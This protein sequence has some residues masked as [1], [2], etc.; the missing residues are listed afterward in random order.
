M[1]IPSYTLQ[2]LT[3]GCCASV[4]L[5]PDGTR[6]VKTQFEGHE[7]KH[8]VEKMIYE[9]LGSHPSIARY[10]GEVFVAT[11]SSRKAG[12][13]LQYHPLR[14]LREV[15]REPKKMAKFRDRKL[16]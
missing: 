11:E 15:M 13:L 4:F 14:T 12:L 5:L 6:V 9:R 1:E 8:A 3:T 2:Y 16:E 10:Y 7:H